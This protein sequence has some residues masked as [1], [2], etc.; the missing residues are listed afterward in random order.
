MK[1]RN[2]FCRVRLLK[3]GHALLCATLLA[4]VGASTVQAQQAAQSGPASSAF[5]D[6]LRVWN[7]D[8]KE[9]TGGVFGLTF[10]G[11]TRW[12]EKTGVSF[13][14]AVDQQDMLSRIRVGAV[15][16]P[17]SWLRVSATGQDSR[18]P[19]Y[20]TV[21]PAT[22]RDSIDLQEAYIELFARQKTGFGASL[23]RAMI[24]YGETRVIGVPQWSNVARTY[25]HARLY[26]RTKNTRFEVLML[27]PVK[28]L[29]DQFNKPE[30][31][32]RIWGTYNT[33]TSLGHGISVDVYALRHSQNKIGGWAGAGTLGTN[34]FGG[35]FYGTLPLSFTYSL[36]G[37]GQ[38]GHIGLLTQRAY[39]WF[40]G[41]AKK[42][43]GK[44]PLTLSFEAKAASGTGRGSTSSGTYDQLAP[45]NHDKFGHEDLFGWRN[46]RTIKNLETFSIT[47][48]FALNLM[49]TNHWLSSATDSLYNGQGSSL[50]L[51]KTGAAGTHV[52]QELDSF[53]TYTRGG[54]TFG[55]G[56]G[57][58]FAGEFIQK[59][60]PGVNP[61][62]L[63]VFHQYSFK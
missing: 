63:Y 29:G 51:S 10:E 40:A 32:D 25:D 48:R 62:Y 24:N 14:K 9:G 13:G 50:A 16:E 11:R 33:F 41:A 20:G 22:M 36:E 49:Y 42:F 21:A 27:S 45:A 19:F 18:V 38:T 34:S 47:K 30:L 57:H 5:Q 59:A 61:R 8:L 15:L 39:A 35:R 46:L 56:F 31:G 26:Y 58:F 55:A 12:E 1:M 52:G 54:Q 28:I 7:A 23:G 53:V 60:T 2:Q 37:I 43:P 17:V 4:A 3:K 6:P 44:H